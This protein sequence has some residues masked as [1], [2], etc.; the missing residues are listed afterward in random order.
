MPM[1]M[2]WFFQTINDDKEME[3]SQKLLTD[4]RHAVNTRQSLSVFEGT[5]AIGSCGA[6]G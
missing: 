6:G 2:G 3:N 5:S 1:A 4:F